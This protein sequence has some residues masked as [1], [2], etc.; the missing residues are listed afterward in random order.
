MST[1]Q[2]PPGVVGRPRSWIIIIGTACT[3]GAL[4]AVLVLFLKGNESRVSDAR[5]DPEMQSVTQDGRYLELFMEYP[6]LVRGES[7]KFNVHLTVLA[8]GMPVR[9]ES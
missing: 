4:G 9:K 6:L 3:L 1:P 2:I 5:N 7:A 8:D